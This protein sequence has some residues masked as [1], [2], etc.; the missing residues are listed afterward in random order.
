[1]IEHFIYNQKSTLDFG[2]VVSCARTYNSTSHDSE[3]VSIAGRN[4]DLKIYKNRYKNERLQYTCA[5]IDDIVTAD[6]S[7][8]AFR[9]FMMHD[10]GYHRLE[11]SQHPDIFRTAEYNGDLSVKMASGYNLASFIVEFDCK[12]Q[13][14]L[15]LGE[16]PVEF[17]ENT[18]LGNPTLYE[19]KPL[20]R[21]YGTGSIS[22]NGTAIQVTTANGYTD[23]D[24]ELQD[25]YKGSV[26]CNNNI[27]LNNGEFPV[28]KAGENDIIVNGFSKVELTPNWWT[29]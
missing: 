16:M 15:K 23:I 2:I 21:V 19:A 9:A 3:T 22:I 27:V 18:K 12:P 13:R 25:A 4:G 7:L 17:S 10:K 6:E 20:I 5:I 11:D 26:N 29:L 8:D 1:M 28:L 14:F 24:C